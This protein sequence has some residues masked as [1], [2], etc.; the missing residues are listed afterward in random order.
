MGVQAVVT[1]CLVRYV[2]LI[3][4]DKLPSVA[5]INEPAS[6]A[7]GPGAL[8]R[9]RPK[10]LA[11]STPT[12]LLSLEEARNR[13]LQLA[14]A[15][16]DTHYI[17]VGGGPASLPPKYHTVID[18][19]GGDHRKRGNSLKHKK[20]PI[21]WKSLFVKGRTP[22]ASSTSSNK[23]QR[24]GSSASTGSTASMPA[25][26]TST[27]RAVTYIRPKLRPVKSAES[28]VAQSNRNSTVISSFTSLLLITLLS[29]S[30]VLILVIKTTGN[31]GSY[32]Y[33]HFYFLAIFMG[34]FQIERPETFGAIQNS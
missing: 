21:G 9:T 30:V 1:E 5:T 12:K 18:L 28:L 22:S 31:S 15:I 27:Q 29:S 6:G 11:I 26:S 14:T 16:N 17:E 2:E 32:S 3:F 8:K 4:S 33:S 34:F 24:K 23:A 25:A 20:S 10:S 19:P 7:S 13:A